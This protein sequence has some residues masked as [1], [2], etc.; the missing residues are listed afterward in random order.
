LARAV[1]LVS[2]YWGLAKSASQLN[3]LYA[4]T[5]SLEACFGW[6]VTHPQ[7]R[8]GQKKQEILALLK[9]LEED[10]PRFVCEIG[11]ARGGTLFLL[12]RVCRRDAT[13]ITVDTGLS[14]ERRLV[15]SRFGSDAQKIR[16]VRGS[17]H[18]ERTRQAVETFLDGNKL[19]LLFI[20]GDHSYEGAK[21]DFEIYSR[22]VRKGGLIAFHDIMPDYKSRFGKNT[23][24]YVGGVPILWNELKDTART[25]ELI[26]GPDQDGYGIG[27]LYV[28]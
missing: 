22:Y 9:I 14:P 8:S 7:L 3:R 23:D 4:D 24:S 6:T 2:D 15:Y 21:M 12:S 1:K 16:C 17:S 28:D 27:L 19:D 11:T 20:D 5:Q 25:K 10:P 26:E 13:I 18:E